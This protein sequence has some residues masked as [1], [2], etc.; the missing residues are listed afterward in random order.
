M[1]E[2]TIVLS[3][4]VVTK[5][6]VRAFDQKFHTGLNIIRGENGSGKTTIADFIFFALGGDTPQWRAEAATCD[7]I[8]AEVQINGAPLTFRRQIEQEK[9]RPMSIFWDSFDSAQGSQ[10]EWQ[11]Y[12]YAGTSAKESFS[13]VV[14]RAAGIPEVKGEL[15]ARVTLHQILRLLYVDQKTDYDA[16]F[17]TDVFD[18]QLT[19]EAVGDLLCGVYDD[20]LYLAESQ[21]SLKQGEK[22]ALQ[23]ELKTILSLLGDQAAPSLAWLE[24]EKAERRHERDKAYADLN[25]IRDRVPV[26]G[27]SIAGRR[28]ELAAELA[29]QNELVRGLEDSIRQAKIDIA[30]RE[31]FLAALDQRLVALSESQTIHDSLGALSFQFCPACY[32]PL[33]AQE[34]ACHLCKNTIEVRGGNLLRLRHELEQQIRESKTMQAQLIRIRPTNPG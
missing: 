11:L 9:G 23:S 17:R 31:E 30:D 29:K 32:A 25:G 18:Q 12:P 5:A 3:R 14:F 34:N 21:L 16:L 26:A 8:F 28:T 1:F 10:T 24:Q 15:S 6:G 20:G 22:S 19:R 2:P 33:T 13:Q 27:Q 4:L 7:Y